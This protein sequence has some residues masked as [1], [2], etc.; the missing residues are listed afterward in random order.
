MS[1]KTTYETWKQ[2]I[3]SDDVDDC[4][5]NDMFATMIQQYADEHDMSADD[6]DVIYKLISEETA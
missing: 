4:V 1:Y 5:E 6:Y 2:Y 3:K